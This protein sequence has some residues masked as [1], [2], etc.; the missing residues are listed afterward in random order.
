[1]PYDVRILA[2]DSGVNGLIELVLN[3][4]FDGSWATSAHT[5]NLSHAG[6]GLCLWFTILPLSNANP[7]PL[8]CATW[9]KFA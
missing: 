1:M 2:R 8:N 5:T 6:M 3:M 9:S 4:Y 7:C